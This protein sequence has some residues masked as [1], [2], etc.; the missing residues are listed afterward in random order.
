MIKVLRPEYVPYIPGRKKLSTTVLDDRHKFHVETANARRP[1]VQDSVML[2][3]G[4]KN[5]SS[6]AKTV[7]TMLH[8]INTD[9]IFLQAVDITG[10]SETGAKLEEIVQE[11]IKIAKEKIG[12]NV[13]AVLSDNASNMKLMG[14]LTNL[15]HS[16]CKSHTGNLLAENLVDKNL[17]TAVLKIIKEF[18]QADFENYIVGL[19]GCRMILPCDT[20]W[21]S[22]RN[23][24]KR[25]IMNLPHKKAHARWK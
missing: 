9:N 10:S 16:T 19:G 5:S 18:K 17:K 7:V 22:Y 13:Y 3:D 1:D 2:I 12:T 15:W 11:S 25:L 4:W 24:Y 20:R 21:C 14:N 8:T 6:N 23:A